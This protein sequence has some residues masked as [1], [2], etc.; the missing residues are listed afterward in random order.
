MPDMFPLL[1]PTGMIRVPCRYELQESKMLS[2]STRR[3][4]YGRQTRDEAAEVSPSFALYAVRDLLVAEVLLQ[5]KN[6]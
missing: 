2:M 6:N 1:S 4:E 5:D 3:H